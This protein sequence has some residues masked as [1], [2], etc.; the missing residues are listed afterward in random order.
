MFFYKPTNHI[1]SRVDHDH[2]LERKLAVVGCQ[3]VDFLVRCE[4][5]DGVKQLMDLLSDI[6]L[7]LSEVCKEFSLNFKKKY[8]DLFSL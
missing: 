1:F 4:Q 8:T 6:A 2:E 3:L 5:E 7:C